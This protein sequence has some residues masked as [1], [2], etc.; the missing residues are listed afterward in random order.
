MKRKLQVSHEVQTSNRKQTLSV[1]TV[2]LSA[3]ALAIIVALAVGNA[4]GDRAESLGGTPSSTPPIYEYEGADVQPVDAWYLSLSGQTVESIS[5]TI[6]SLPQSV[7]AVSIYLR[8]GERAPEYYSPVYNTVTG[9]SSAGISLSEI[10]NLIHSKGLYVIG[11]F[12]LNSANL[13]SGSAG[14]ALADFET[15]LI[16]EA[17]SSGIDEIVITN[18]PSDER[19][20]SAVSSIFKAVR[21]KNSRVILGAAIGYKI[22][23]SNV[24][25][26]ALISYSKFADF[27]AVD[28]SMARASGTSASAIVS[29]LEYLF[30]SYPL[31]LLFEISDNEDRQSQSLALKQLGITN[32]QSHKQTTI[33]STPAG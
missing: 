7:S 26:A 27:C 18:L 4:L 32:L 1:L 30:R 12:D 10:V 22:M 21:A 11:C 5:A 8:S 6:E 14:T 15:S 9:M 29:E 17:A 13:T 28:A 3:A 25:A 23:C 16:C 2:W 33:S 19:G 20:I 24:G 31:R